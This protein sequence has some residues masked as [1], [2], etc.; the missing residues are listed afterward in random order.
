M[1]TISN[2]RAE[3]HLR[4]LRA[5]GPNYANSETASQ[6]LVQLR[7]RTQPCTWDETN[8]AHARSCFRTDRSDANYPNAESSSSKQIRVGDTGRESSSRWHVILNENQLAENMTTNTHQ[9]KK[10]RREQNAQVNRS[11]EHMAR[12]ENLALFRA[13]SA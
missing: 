1:H 8:H 9:Q 3:M 4:T 11:R 10:S 13:G 12:K 5:N 2:K 6:N 7:R